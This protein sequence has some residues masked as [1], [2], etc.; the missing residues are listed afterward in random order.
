MPQI[1]NITLRFMDSTVVGN[2]LKKLR[3]ANCFTQEQVADYIGITRSAYSNYESGDREA[4][5]EVLEKAAA[6][7]G[8]DLDV[9]FEEN[10]DVL[11]SML[12]TAFRIKDLSKQDMVEVASFKEVVMNYLKMDR[13]L[14]Q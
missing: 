13:L 8:C 1:S 10:K 12:V 9:L 11:E 4:P 6:L 14:A 3:E 7:F 2:N 5:L